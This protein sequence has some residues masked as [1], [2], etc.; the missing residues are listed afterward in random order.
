MGYISK[1][2]LV[3]ALKKVIANTTANNIKL[4]YHGTPRSKFD[5]LKL[6]QKPTSK[7]IYGNGLYFTSKKRAAESFATGRYG[8]IFTVDLSN[9]RIWDAE[10]D[11]KTAKI[12]ANKLGV[13]LPIKLFL[14]GWHTLMVNKD[15]NLLGDAKQKM[16]IETLL[17]LGFDGIDVLFQSD[18]H[19]YII[20]KN[21]DKIKYIKKEVKQRKE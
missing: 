4:A 2:N 17:Q 1:V 6:E 8:V 7:Q 19:W 12:L 14:D 21:I 13:T 20:Y 9:L 5:V 11:L 16:M 3:S 15:T 10:H 18:E